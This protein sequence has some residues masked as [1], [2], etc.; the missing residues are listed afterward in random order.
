MPAIDVNEPKYLGRE[1]QGKHYCTNLMK[2]SLG[3]YRSQ[4]VYV[5]TIWLCLYIF[6]YKCILLIQK[7]PR[8]QWRAQNKLS[9][10]NFKRQS[11]N[12]VQRVNPL[13]I[14]KHSYSTEDL[15]HVSV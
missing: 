9:C 1:T 11:S 3:I 10:L 5:Y 4:I 12:T 2:I 6:F 15:F 7:K 8:S 14:L 13:H